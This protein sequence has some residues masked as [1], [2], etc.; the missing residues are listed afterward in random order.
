M[1]VLPNNFGRRRGMCWYS[2]VIWYTLV[3]VQYLLPLCV[4][5]TY[6]GVPSM[7][8]NC[9]RYSV[10]KASGISGGIFMKLTFISLV[11]LSELVFCLGGM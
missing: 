10:T 11:G 6:I 3:P 8:A 1:I 9:S 4:L 5:V 2:F 7:L